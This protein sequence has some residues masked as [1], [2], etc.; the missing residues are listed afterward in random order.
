MNDVYKVQDDWLKNAKVNKEQ[1]EKMY[2]Y[3]VSENE[4]FW[5]EQ[6]KRIDWFQP[7]NK[8]RDVFYSKDDVKIRWY[9]DGTTNVTYNCVYRHA[10]NT[11]DKIAII[12]EGDAP[13]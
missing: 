8:I 12:W 2:Q 11:P 1:Y 4:N 3:S 9:Y 5:A 6:G 10:K 7:Y 13:T